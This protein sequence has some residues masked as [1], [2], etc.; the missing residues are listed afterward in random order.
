MADPCL[1]S[2]PEEDGSWESRT[3]QTELKHLRAYQLQVRELHQ[4][5]DGGKFEA[6][7]Q[8]ATVYGVDMNDLSVE[9]IENAAGMPQELRAGLYRALKWHFLAGRI[10]QLVDYQARQKRKKSTGT[11]PR[12]LRAQK[13]FPSVKP[14]AKSDKDFE[15]LCVPGHARSRYARYH[16]ALP[17]LAGWWPRQ[18]SLLGTGLDLHLIWQVWVRDSGGY[19]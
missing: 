13:M 7:E 15:V 17:P 10:M 5:L 8:W 4:W 14:I 12:W 19:L 16:S 2:V 9:I 18:K 11:W 6:L 1:S 3:F